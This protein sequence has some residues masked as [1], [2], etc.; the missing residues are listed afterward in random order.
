[1]IELRKLHQ[2]AVLAEELNFRR[3]AS[4]LHMSQ[5]PLSIALQTLE[6]E[7]G[8]RL[9]DRSRQH[10]RLTP[11]GTLFLK[12]VQQIL[13][14]AQGAVERARRAAQGQ[15]GVLRLS[16]VPSA[17]LDVLPR[18]F[19]RFQQDYPAVQMQLVADT[20]A[21]QLEQLRRGETDLALVVGPV[22]DAR[23]LAMHDVCTQRF[24]IAVPQG[25]ALAA[26]NTVKVRELAEECFISF[27]AAQGAGFAG[28]LRK[29]CHA[30]GYQPRVV[31]EVSQMQTILTLV[32]GGFG[33]ALVP[34]AMRMAPMKGVEFL[35]LAPTR[36]APVY[37]LVLAH[38][39]HNDNPIIQNFL[40]IARGSWP[41]RQ[42]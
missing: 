32:A 10:V 40:G 22:H 27:P 9:L 18:I 20:T 25:H 15:E 6:E 21:R 3:A 14:H 23:G 35:N 5:P 26:R 12:D 19:K 7:V 28:A 36:P 39:H 2:F 13:L 34:Q 8:V 17:A 42:T 1:M 38:A 11:A 31:Q 29:V 30:A 4:R 37:E 16:F 24:V 41:R 33:I